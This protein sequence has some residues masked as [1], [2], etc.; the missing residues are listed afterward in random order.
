MII[1][2]CY[3]DFSCANIFIQIVI[4]LL[5]FGLYYKVL[6]IRVVR[7]NLT[8]FPVA[9]LLFI[10]AFAQCCVFLQEPVVDSRKFYGG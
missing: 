6:W 7:P 1:I 9:P 8:W 2:I 4:L 5:L 3:H 10:Y